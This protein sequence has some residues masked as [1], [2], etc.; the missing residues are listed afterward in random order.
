MRM[1]E[2]RTHLPFYQSS[3]FQQ[4]KNI[5]FNRKRFIFKQVEKRERTSLSN[6][7]S[8]FLFSQKECL[9]TLLE[10]FI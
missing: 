5:H 7:P 10:L 8:I 9:V 3:S 4:T 6:Y 2:E 1:Q